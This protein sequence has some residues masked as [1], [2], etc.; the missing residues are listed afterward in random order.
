[1]PASSVPTSARLSAAGIDLPPVIFGTSALGNLYRAIEPEAKRAIVAACVTAHQASGHRVVLDSAGK[2]GAGLALSEIRRCLEEL[3]VPPEA[4]LIS[5]KLGWRQVPLRGSE[6]QFEPGV[7][8]GLDHDAE[9]CISAAGIR[10]CYEQG[11]DLLGPYAPAMV[12]VHDPDEYLAAASDAADAQARWDDILAAYHELFALRDAGL[13]RA[14]GVGAKDWRVIERLVAAVP[15]DWVML[16]C[17][18][19]VH[20]HPPA[21]LAFVARCHAQDIAVINSAVFHAGFLTGGSFYDY[22]EPDSVVDADLFAWRAAFHALCAD[23]A[24]DP[25]VACVRFGLD[26]AGAA[27]VALNTSRPERAASNLALG[28]TP[29]PAALWRDAQAAGLIAVQP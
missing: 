25:A 23:H 9:Q 13:V 16:A 29:V 6:P 10:A 2:Y 4:A 22:R 28:S 7:W 11:C 21:L 20:R 5:N 14:V 26:V 3:E 24:V 18:L 19:T 1:M 12:S 17:S 8:Q 27:A 15:L